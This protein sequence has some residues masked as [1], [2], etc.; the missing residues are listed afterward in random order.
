MRSNKL[1]PFFPEIL[2]EIEAEPKRSSKIMILKKYRDVKGL[3]QL[4]F[5]C[6]EPTLKYAVTRKELDNLRYDYV[7]TPT[8]ETAMTNL[9]R[10]YRR[11]R[12]WTNFKNPPLRK[13]K[14]L[15]LISMMFSGLHHEEVEIF[16]QMVN[17]RIKVKGLT[18]NLVRE[19]FPL[20]LSPK[21]PKPPKPKKKSAK[22]EEPKKEVTEE[23][24]EVET[25]TDEVSEE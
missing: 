4:L 17:G 16:K 24:A 22:E 15:D 23:V 21:P 9:F 19:A 11:I 5:F 12:N 8:Y 2:R 1:T 20:L 7:D 10:E 3:P 25:K 18:E 13:A 14:V 6:Y